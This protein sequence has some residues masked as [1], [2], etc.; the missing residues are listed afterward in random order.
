MQTSL[1]VLLTGATFMSVSGLG[2]PGVGTVARVHAA[3][4]ANP[5]A[6]A[7]PADWVLPTASGIQTYT[8]LRG[9]G[10]TF[11]LNQF[12]P[13]GLNKEVRQVVGVTLPTGDAVATWSFTL[14]GGTRTYD[15]VAHVFPVGTQGSAQ[16]ACLWGGVGYLN[17]GHGIAAARPR[18][19][20]VTL[21]ALVSVRTGRPGQVDLRVNG[22]H[23]LVT[24]DTLVRQGCRTSRS[25]GLRC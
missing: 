1:K 15:G 9:G 12:G 20:T 25:D 3:L 11:T 17:L 6:A 16:H 21:D 14:P 13:Q 7:L 5:C 4:P 10:Y 2:V 24:S 23:Y 19:V 8:T 22:A 18:A